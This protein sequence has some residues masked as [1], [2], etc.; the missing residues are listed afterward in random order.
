MNGVEKIQ[1]ILSSEKKIK[2]MTHVVGGFPSLK[3][4]E[5]IVLAMCA[6]GADLVE[7]Q[8]PFSDPTADG[9]VIMSA[10][11]DAL[12]TG[13]TTREVIEMAGRIAKEVDSAI[14]LMSYLN[15]LNAYGF[16]RLVKDIEVS[17]I[18]GFIVPDLPVENN[19]ELVTLCNKAKL[20]FVPLIA[21]TTD[22]ARMKAIADATHSPFVYAVMRLGVTGKETMIDDSAKTYIKTVRKNTGKFVAAGFGIK[23]RDQIDSLYGVADCAIVGSALTACVREALEKGDDPAEKAGAMVKNLAE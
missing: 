19:P 14:L 3:E 5:R 1:N 4:S 11:T 23:S 12:E 21:P 18:A 20:A 6:S 10:N 9:P 13:V 22:Y 17:G 7:I 2:L 16:E 15:P 8:I